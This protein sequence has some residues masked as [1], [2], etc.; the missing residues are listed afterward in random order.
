LLICFLLIDSTIEGV[1]GIIING[2]KSQFTIYKLLLFGA[3][4]LILF[5]PHTL[6][7]VKFLVKSYSMPAGIVH[8]ISLLTYGF[9][10]FLWF[11]IRI[12]LL[13]LAFVIPALAFNSANKDD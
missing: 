9:I 12:I 11:F 6:K 7:Q 3:L 8:Y 4:S 5:L 10:M 13:P 2:V 1:L